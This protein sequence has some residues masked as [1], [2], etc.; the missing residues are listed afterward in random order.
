MLAAGDVAE[1]HEGH[2]VIGG[3]LWIAKWHR[4]ELTVAILPLQRDAP[5]YF[6]DPAAVPGFGDRPALAELTHTEL[7]GDRD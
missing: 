5:V 3:N 6:S 1:G 2:F 7:V 4:H